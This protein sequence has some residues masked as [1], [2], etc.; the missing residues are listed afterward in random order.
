MLRETL[1]RCERWRTDLVL[2]DELEVFVWVELGHDDDLLSHCQSV[3]NM[4][5]QTEP[6]VQRQNSHADVISGRGLECDVIGITARCT[7]KA[8]AAVF[9]NIIIIIIIIIFIVSR[10]LN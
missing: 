7:P 8:W 1:M 9:S 2:G 10:W 4:N 5:A 3:D 6:V